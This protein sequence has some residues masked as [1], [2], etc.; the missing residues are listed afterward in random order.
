MGKVFEDLF[1]DIQEDMVC[2]GLDYV[3]SNADKIYIYGSCEGRMTMPDCFFEVD[4]DVYNRASLR[5]IS[6]DYDVSGENQDI[7]LR[8]ILKG[9]EKMEVLCK[10]YDRPM[11]TEIK[12]IY[13]VNDGSLSVDYKYE[14]VYSQHKDMLP[15]DVVE[16]WFKDVKRSL[17]K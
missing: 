9:I 11:P 10:E 14:P 13:D 1:M 6:D 5:T 15:D 3:D 8:R 17:S 4:G 2:A 16:K 12:M 7:C